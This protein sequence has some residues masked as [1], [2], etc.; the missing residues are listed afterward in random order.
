VLDVLGQPTGVRADDGQG[1]RLGLDHG[2]PERLGQR[3]VQEHVGPGQ[4]VAHGTGA[5]GAEQLH[6]TFEA[7]V[8]NGELRRLAVVPFADDL[9]LHLDSLVLQ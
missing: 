4:Q 7:E 5:L 9:V 8:T 1:H 3:S 6:L 2:H